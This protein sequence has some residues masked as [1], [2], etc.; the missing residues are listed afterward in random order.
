MDG[1]ALN[2]KG[3]FVVEESG[4]SNLLSTIF[5]FILYKKILTINKKG[6]YYYGTFLT[7]WTNLIEASIAHRKVSN[8]AENNFILV[9]DYHKDND[10]GF[11]HFEV[12]M[13]NKQNKSAEEIITAIN[14]FGVPANRI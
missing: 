14:H 7:N 1:F 5:F 13:T 6:I 11:Y 12:A 4:G 2:K 9:L 10:N 3:D 8:T